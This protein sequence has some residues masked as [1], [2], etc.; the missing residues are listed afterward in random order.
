M[1]MIVTGDSRLDCHG[2]PG[3]SEPQCPAERDACAHRRGHGASCP[4]WSD[5]LRHRDIDG[6]DSM[7]ETLGAP[8]LFSHNIAQALRQSGLN[9]GDGQLTEFY[10]KHEIIP[11]VDRGHKTRIKEYDQIAHASP[12]TSSQHCVRSIS[13]QRLKK[14]QRKNETFLEA[15]SGI[16]I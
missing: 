2:S 1:V 6:H 13:S 5:R 7:P 10:T 12:S 3:P 14:Q 4:D 16:V 15:E 8:P 11:W 9:R